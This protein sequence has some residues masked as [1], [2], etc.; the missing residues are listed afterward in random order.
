MTDSLYWVATRSTIGYV[1]FEPVIPAFAQPKT[2][3]L[4][5]FLLS[6]SV[7]Y[8]FNSQYRNFHF[9]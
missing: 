6:Y 3:I 2:I 7:L 8:G 4:M 1:H 9:S 5:F